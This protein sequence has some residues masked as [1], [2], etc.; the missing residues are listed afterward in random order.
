[1][2]L[3]CS[4][5][6]TFSDHLSIFAPP[7]KQQNHNKSNEKTNPHV[8]GQRLK[9]N[10]CINNIY[11]IQYYFFYYYKKFCINYFN[12]YTNNFYQ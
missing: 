11:Y 9:N 12:L 2:N 4:L 6:S 10:I 1:M 7:L 8:E 3:F 5:K